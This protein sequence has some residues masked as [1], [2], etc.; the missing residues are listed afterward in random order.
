MDG[1]YS[2][3]LALR[4][5]IAVFL[6]RTVG[7]FFLIAAIVTLLIAVLSAYNA[8]NGASLLWIIFVLIAALLVFLLLFLAI[9]YF[10]VLKLLPR[11]LTHDEKRRISRFSKTLL[12]RLE[13]A[14]API[15]LLAWHLTVQALTNQRE[16]E[17]RRHLQ[18]TIEHSHSLTHEFKAIRRFFEA[19]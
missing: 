2:T 5:I 3:A 13:M 14:R 1:M 10:A 11:K 18:T 12:E 4:A 8:M 17:Q 6:E 16:S 9:T 19:H 7:R 15:P